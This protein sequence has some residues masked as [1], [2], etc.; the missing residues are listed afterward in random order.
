ML[1][2]TATAQNSKPDAISGRVITDSGQPLPGAGITF[3]RVGS[4]DPRNV[5]TKHTTSDADGKF[6]VSG[7]KPANYM[8]VAFLKGYAPLLRI[9]GA[10]VNLHRIGD[11]VNVVMTKGGVITGRVTTQT[12]EP[13]VGVRVSAQIINFAANFTMDLF[14]LTALTDDRGIYRIYGLP[15][16][17]YVVWAGGSSLFRGSGGYAD[18]D[19][20][21][22]DVRTFAPSSTR[23]TAQEIVVHGGVE[24]TNVDIQ[25]R[26]GAGHT[27]S[28]KASG[29]KGGPPRGFIIML[30]A[31]QSTVTSYQRS[32]EQ[33][34]MFEGVDDGVYN[35][36]ALSFTEAGEFMF[37][38]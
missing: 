22:K 8:I 35:V 9:T 34:F 33:G 19:P 13:V 26:G 32:D 29:P 11:F 36:S 21:D 23:D 12:G 24:T 4:S 15:E 5:E 25:Y 31:S 3:I 28:G 38:P 30:A 6:E 1:C 16:A 18:L 17:S 20:Y 2:I 37:A 7:L 27:I 10:S 14:N